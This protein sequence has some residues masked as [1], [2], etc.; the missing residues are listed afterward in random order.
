[1]VLFALIAGAGARRDPGALVAIPFSGAIRVLV[2]EVLAPG[3]R[4]WT[5]ATP[6][7]EFVRE[8]TPIQPTFDGNRK[9]RFWRKLLSLRASAESKPIDD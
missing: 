9:E 6:D 4:R 7:I 5:G 2:I 8:R 1:M 3:F